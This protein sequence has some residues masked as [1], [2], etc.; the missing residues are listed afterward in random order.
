MCVKRRRCLFARR[1]EV[2][3]EPLTKESGKFCGED[4]GVTLRSCGGGR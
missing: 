2:S 4:D 3:C 1:G